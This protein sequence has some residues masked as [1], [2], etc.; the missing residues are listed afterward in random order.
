MQEADRLQ[1]LH[2]DPYAHP[3]YAAQIAKIEAKAAR[4]AERAVV[5]AAKEEKEMAA[6]LA[7]KEEMAAK[8]AAA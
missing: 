2:V 8:A 4:D 1:G 7:A 5:L 3:A 6:K